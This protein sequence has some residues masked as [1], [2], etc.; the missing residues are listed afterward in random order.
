MKRIFHIVA[1]LLSSITYA[2]TGNLF[3]VVESGSAAT[4]DI[5]LCLNG[6]GP[7]SCEKFHVSAQNI[8]IS[9]TINRVYPTVGIKILTP[10]YRPTGCTPDANGYCLFAVNGQT[11]TEITV[12]STS[13]YTVG[14]RI[15]GLA[16]SVT[17]QNNGRDSLTQATDGRFT[18]T[19]PLASGS[20]YNV[21]VSSQ[22]A[23]QTCTVSNGTGTVTGSNVTNVQVVCSTHTHMLGGTI[24]GLVGSV[25]LQ[26]NGGDTLTRTT[27]GSFTF[28]TPVAEGSPY[29]VTVSSQ[30][31]TQTCM[32]TNGSGTMGS[33][34]V[35]NVAVNCTEN[36]TTLS[37]SATNTIPVGSGFGSITVTNTGTMH[38][39]LNVS[40]SLP[41]GWTDVIQDASGCTEIAPNNGT[42]ILTFT[43]PTPYIAQGGLAVIGDNI[44]NTPITAVAFTVQ[45]FLV[46]E[47]SSP[48]TV[49]VVDTEQ[50]ASDGWGPIG[51]TIGTDMTDGVA[52]T[53]AIVT[54][55]GTSNN[56][57][58]VICNQ[59][60]V[61]G[62][63]VGEWYLPAAC[64]LGPEGGIA[65][66]PAG[67]AN[68]QTNLI[69]VGFGG[70]DVGHAYLSSSED[71]SDP[72]NRIWN[73]TI[74]TGV[75]NP[76][77]KGSVGFVSCVRSLI[78]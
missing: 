18:F 19:I 23:T 27:N 51:Q 63:S 50:F 12:N 39:A 55:L 58:A 53:N 49:Q 8:Q 16:G 72:D 54:A 29:N 47:I 36:V 44:S 38:P 24:S 41:S 13:I 65:G 48:T 4:A 14:G 40:L 57:G 1:L 32:V 42:C 60:T 31:V 68:I 45:G 15:T 61:G 73:E 56:Y 21:T 46:W 67:L 30:P 70:F 59:S 52:N 43:S 9:T 74:V 76:I 75:L 6:K 77:S 11:P 26:N 20:T 62:A 5:I 7:L 25:S 78:Y 33:S 66:C 34:D 22:P 10:G 2:Q 37:V 69:N 28:S 3:N 17:L 71:A 35:I 64:Q